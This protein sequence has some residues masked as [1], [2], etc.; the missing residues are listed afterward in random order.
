MSTFKNNTTQVC[1]E[2]L[3]DYFIIYTVPLKPTMNETTKK[4]SISTE[5]KNV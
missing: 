4:Y 5:Q 2:R 1:W 3:K